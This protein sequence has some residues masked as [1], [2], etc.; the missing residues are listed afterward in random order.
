MKKTFTRIASV[1][2]IALLCCCFGNLNAQ[3]LN[4]PANWPNGDWSLTGSYVT[5][6]DILEGDPTVDANFAYDDDDA[7]S[8]NINDIAAV[9]PV[10]DLTAASTGGEQYLELSADYVYNN[11]GSDFINVEW[12][13]ADAGAWQL[14]VL[15]DE[16]GTNTPTNNF[17]S[18][19][20]DPLDAPAID[21]S[22]FSANQLENFQYR[23]MF[24][25]GG[26][27]AWGFC[28]SSPTLI[29]VAEATIEGCTD[30]TAANYDPAANT[31]DGSCFF[32]DCADTTPL[33]ETYCYGDNENGI[34]AV[35]GS[36]TPGEAVTIEFESGDLAFGDELIIYDGPS[37]NDPVLLTLT[38]TV[39]ISGTVVE[40]T[41][42][43]ISLGTSTGGFASCQS[44]STAASEFVY[45]VYCGQVETPGCTD[46]TAAN[47][48]P[49]ATI[50]DGS[51]ILAACEDEP[52]SATYC[53]DNN[54]DGTPF[55]VYE[56][57]T[58]GEP[59]FIEFTGGSL[60]TC[61]DDI[62]IYDGADETAA[63]LYTGTGGL[64]GI[65][66]QSTGDF[67]SIGVDSDGSVSCVSGS[68]SAQ[69]FQY[70]VYCG[71]EVIPGCTDETAANYNP[72]ATVD[73]GSCIV[74]AEGESFINIEVGGGSFTGEVSWELQD[75]GGV[76]AISGGAPYDQG[77]CI[78]DGC[79]QFEM[80]DSF[81]DGWNGNTYLITD[82]A[83]DT[84][85]TGTL[86]DGGGPVINFTPIGGTVE[87][88]GC[89]IPGCTDETALN[90]DPNATEDDGSCVYPPEN[91]DC[92]DAT[93]VTCG[94]SLS[95][96]TAFSTAGIEGDSAW[97]CNPDITPGN[98]Y[99]YNGD[100][101]Q[102]TA[103]TCG[104]S[105]DTEITIFTIGDCGDVETYECVANNDDDCG[106]QSSISFPTTAGVDYYIHVGNFSFSANAGDYSITFEC[107]EP[108]TPVP[109]NVDCDNATFLLDSLE[110]AGTTVCAPP[111]AQQ[112]GCVGFNTTYGVWYE[113]T[114]TQVSYYFDIQ[115][116]GESGNIG[117]SIYS[118]PSGSSDPCLDATTAGDLNC[119]GPV[120]GNIVGPLADFFTV[121]DTYFVNIWS[122]G[123]ANTT[124][125][126][127]NAWAMIEGCTDPAADNYVPDA[128]FPDGS[129]TYANAP[130]ND[131]CADAIAIECG[132]TLEGSVGGA[133]AFEAPAGCIATG[134]GV[135][136]TVEGADQLYT[137]SLCG[138]DADT[139]VS[140]YSGECGALTCIGSSANDPTP[141]DDNECGFEFQDDG[142]LEWVGSV[143]ET[144][145]IYVESQNS[146][147]N[148][149]LTLECEEVIVGCGNPAAANYNPDANVIDNTLCDFVFEAACG[150]TYTYC[151][152]DNAAGTVLTYN[153][154]NEGDIMVI[155]FNSGSVE[156]TWDEIYIYDGDNV[157]APVL[158]S[159]APYGNAGDMTG[160]SYEASGSSISVQVD[161][162]G[163]FSCATGE[164][165]PELNFTI[166]CI[167]GGCTEPVACNYD[168]V[169]EI[170]D[171]SCEFDSC[172]GCTYPD[173]E[174]YDE[175]ALIDD[176][177]C[178]FDCPDSTCPED[179]T[180]D[181][182]V[183]TDDLLQFLGAYGSTCPT[184]N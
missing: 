177:S 122:S 183:Q 182:I 39:D 110:T 70:T 181:G 120:T 81:G 84:L 180:E 4:E 35:Y 117:L 23:I 163:I 71:S 72:D 58:P 34:F 136:Y 161:S 73:D 64:A 87:E 156:N 67:I 97:I 176:G 91:D 143:G 77:Q 184:V 32:V 107:S 27:W 31:D 148:F 25:D 13:D 123:S 21:I 146:T 100:G 114:A 59:I 142:Y 141:Q 57:V 42:D 116:L 16:D 95:G 133:S 175:T 89:T 36:V 46:D 41:G 93:P 29:S 139:R 165:S 105:T 10:Y 62:F 154:E 66:V 137:A 145:Y 147:A 20:P 171:G 65:V 82:G 111:Q 166:T 162:D 127:I 130:A 30:D 86:D 106:V 47:Y 159:G 38:G 33:N 124:D 104:S 52:I 168:P 96:S 22:G 102:F 101:Q 170:D 2:F 178:T 37:T 179:L 48:D 160:L 140:V 14:W 164:I 5:G 26:A 152:G 80:F 125:F 92:V 8:A 98:W 28:F 51:C 157:G 45:N 113:F 132:Q 115:N 9:S 1:S 109:A 74:C 103:S 155:T 6:P 56:A 40:A 151:Y 138:S 158:N 15:L 54:E 76:V 60:E 121:G 144:Y 49:L 172:Q 50:D 119:V 131:T 85:Y 112:P 7:G 12:W 90:Y 134:A 17:C 108:C 68:S 19:V 94:D 61:C 135:W 43:V 69:E 24:D 129:C 18:A 55:A 75:E 3:I 174:N 153:A 78:A 118:A 11:I 149:D 44:G 173:A 128:N 79:Y 150:G 167:P 126:T 88:L 99:V 169:A 83:G 53:Y 63:V